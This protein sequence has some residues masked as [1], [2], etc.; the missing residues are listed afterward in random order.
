[1]DEKKSESIGLKKF[2][3]IAPVI[4]R[5]VESNTEYFNGIAEKPIDMPYLGLR[6]YWICRSD[7]TPIPF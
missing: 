3:I 6:K 1:M 5:Q 4:N 7:L 2:S